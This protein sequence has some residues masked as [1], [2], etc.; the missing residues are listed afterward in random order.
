MALIK[1]I[2]EKTGLAVG[3]V[4]FGLMLFI[5]G[6]DILGPNS[7]IMG[8][9]K[10][11]VGAIAGDKISL[12]EY[13]QQIEEMKY[14]YT[15]NA[16]RN[17]S[18]AEMYSIRQ[19]AWDFL[20]V[21][22]A[23]QK[24]FE[25][26][27]VEVTDDELVDMV[28]GRNVHPEIE[29]AFTDS[30]GNFDRERVTAYLQNLSRMPQQQQAQW[31]MFE[32]NLP[33]SRQRI[34]YDNLMIKSSFVT[35]AEAR[36][37]YVNDNTVAEVKYLYIPYY[38][39]DDSLVNVEESDLKNY[40]QRNQS[41]YEVE[42][43]RDINYVTFPV[44]PSSADSTYVKESLNDLKDTF[45]ESESDS[46]FARTQTDAFSA[47]QKYQTNNLPDPLRANVSNLTEGD[48][49]GPYLSNNAYVL[50]KVSRIFEDTVASARASHILI[51][52]E[53]MNDDAS[54][55][56]ARQEA[57]RILRELQSGAD[58]EEMARE[59]SDDPS[60]AQGGDLGWFTEG[61]MVEPFEN[62]V[63]NASSPGLIS[64][65]IETEYGYHIIKVTEAPTNEAYYVATIER[66]ILPGDDTRNEAYRLA[67]YFA[68][69]TD[70]LKDFLDNTERDSLQIQT[71][72]NVRPNDRRAGEL[73]NAREL[74]RWAYNEASVG[75]ASPVFEIEDNYVV[76]ALTGI[77]EAGQADLADVQSEIEQEVEEE[78]KAAII[79]ER[80]QAMEGTLEDMANEYGQDA[81]VY[82]TSDLKLSSNTLPSVGLA[83][84]AVGRAFAL[85]QGERS[86]PI[87]T[88]NGILILEL[89]AIT[90]APDT[91]EY[92]T[93]REQIAQQEEGRVSFQ[94]GQAVREFADIKDERYRFY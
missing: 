25:E 40:L 76:A 93:Y 64:R 79:K 48:V 60:A 65:V 61:R 58:F 4:A 59:E 57:Q 13:Q 17:P 34:K 15:L 72:E 94:L 73:G 26:L 41:K 43:G 66:Q 21:K 36:N 71:A 80:I 35:S 44:V 5:V 27:G 50:H 54:K 87:E 19:Q 3:L 89:T 70:N 85:E 42:E 16:G 46:A 86:E 14:N 45:R 90:E 56:E 6:G 55:N 32:K 63:F 39:V 33:P 88:D 91:E 10:N 20:V 30:L 1:K 2:R 38:S 28:Q 23:F 53:D 77:T 37:A 78:K 24:Q 29:R 82:N 51:T 9:N 75:D 92:S 18:D 11:E 74:I 49:R 8:S 31:Y 52:P 83:P 7:V 81:R 68:G 67:D 62:A 69:T 12:Q 84:K 22:H 47:Y